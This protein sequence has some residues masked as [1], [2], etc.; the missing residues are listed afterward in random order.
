MDRWEALTKLEGMS[1]AELYSL[2]GMSGT[3]RI[4]GESADRVIH[5]V[6]IRVANSRRSRV[7]TKMV[8]R[9]LEKLGA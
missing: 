2:L 3:E 6:R 5:A 8:A 4:E 1:D 7:V 9:L